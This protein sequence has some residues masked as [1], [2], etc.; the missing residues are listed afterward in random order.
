MARRS[1]Q[2]L[3]ARKDFQYNSNL[4]SVLL[5]TSRAD[6]ADTQEG[7]LLSFLLRDPPPTM[8]HEQLLNCNATFSNTSVLSTCVWAM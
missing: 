1:A 6:M 2:L 7:T 4:S 3:R 5:R 8:A